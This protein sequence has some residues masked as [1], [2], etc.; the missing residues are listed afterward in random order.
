MAFRLTTPFNG[1]AANGDPRVV[2]QLITAYLGQ[3]GPAGPADV[4]AFAGMLRSQLAAIAWCL[5]LALG[6]RQADRARRAFGMRIVTSAAEE[7]PQVMRAL[8]RWALLLR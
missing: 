6:H 8:D 5:W 7:M 2:H 3:G 1:P 4:S